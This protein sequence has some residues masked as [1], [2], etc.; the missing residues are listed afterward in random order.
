[1]YFARFSLKI[2][3]KLE[4]VRTTITTTAATET[5]SKCHTY[6]YNTYRYSKYKYNTYK[7]TKY[8]YNKH[9][10]NKNKYNKYKYSKVTIPQIQ[11]QLITHAT[12]CKYNMQMQ[13]VGGLQGQDLLPPDVWIFKDLLRFGQHLPIPQS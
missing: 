3:Q 13:M 10:Y 4:E 1:M 6:K 2:L 5:T 9:K 12:Q 8:K 7:Y 11:S